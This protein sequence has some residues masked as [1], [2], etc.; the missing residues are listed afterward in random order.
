[1][2]EKHAFGPT[3]F[4]LLRGFNCEMKTARFDCPRTAAGLSTRAQVHGGILN[5]LAGRSRRG[6]SKQKYWNERKRRITLERRGAQ[7]SA[8]I[9]GFVNK[10]ILIVTC[11]TRRNNLLHFFRYPNSALAHDSSIN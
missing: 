11:N 6:A 5:G 3:V 8:F 10:Q 1:M 9:A 2:E 7:Y 4:P